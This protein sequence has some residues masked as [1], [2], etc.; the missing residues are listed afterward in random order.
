MTKAAILESEPKSQK[1]KPSYIKWFHEI[2]IEDVP[3]VGGK[4][5]SLGEMFREL[6]PR[7]V[8][9][10]DGFAITAAGYWHVLRETR[11]DQFIGARLL[12]LDPND[13]KDLQKRGAKQGLICI[14]IVQRTN[15][16]LN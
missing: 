12:D 11:L 1:T 8:E 13:V 6:T 5:A 2:G 3:I 16:L 4:T 15:G 9:V 10:P 14:L 7:G